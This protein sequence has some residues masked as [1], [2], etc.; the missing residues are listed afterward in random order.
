MFRDEED[1][2]LWRPYYTYKRVTVIDG[3]ENEEW[4]E[5]VDEDKDA[6]WPIEGMFCLSPE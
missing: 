2:N 5:D 4:V 1:P 6:V 3:V